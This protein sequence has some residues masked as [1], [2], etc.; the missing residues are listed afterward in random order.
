MDHRDNP[1]TWTLGKINAALFLPFIGDIS[2]GAS[3]ALDPLDRGERR[4]SRLRHRD[5]HLP[6]PTR[7]GELAKSTC[8]FLDHLLLRHL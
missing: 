3:A 2:S 7:N 1:K 4:R 8:I 6:A 5:G